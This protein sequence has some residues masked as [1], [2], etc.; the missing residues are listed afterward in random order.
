MLFRLNLSTRVVL[1]IRVLMSFNIVNPVTDEV[2]MML[3]TPF[4]RWKSDSKNDL[5]K[6]SRPI[7][8]L[9]VLTPDKKNQVRY[10]VNHS[11]QIYINNT[12]GYV[13]VIIY[14]NCVVDRVFYWVKSVAAREVHIRWCTKNV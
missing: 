3:E 14:R 9:S 2:V 4:R 11:V 10:S 7:P 1:F 6:V 13:E 5:L 8:I 12:L